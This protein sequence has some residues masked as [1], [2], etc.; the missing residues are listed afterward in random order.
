MNLLAVAI[1]YLAFGVAFYFWAAPDLLGEFL[2][3]V[4]VFA[5]WPLAWIREFAN[6]FAGMVSPLGKHR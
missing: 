2:G 1:A 4:I 5:L 3:R 6:W